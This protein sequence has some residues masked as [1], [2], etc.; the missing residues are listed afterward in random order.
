MQIPVVEEIVFLLLFSIALFWTISYLS[1]FNSQ[2]S[3][4][5]WFGFWVYGLLLFFAS[6]CQVTMRNHDHPAFR[7]CMPDEEKEM[8]FAS[9]SHPFFLRIS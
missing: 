9:Q 1:F 8:P 4:G 6:R 5:L 7:M 2:Y 3:L